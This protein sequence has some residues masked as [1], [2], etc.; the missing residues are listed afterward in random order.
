[1]TREDVLRVCVGECEAV[2]YIGMSGYFERRLAKHREK[3]YPR[4]FTA[5]YGCDRLVHVETYTRV[6]D[7]LSREKEL[8]GWRREKKIALIERENPEW[9]DLAPREEE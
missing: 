5:K 2:L 6:V 8:K 7:A 3:T 4:S 9:R 1:L